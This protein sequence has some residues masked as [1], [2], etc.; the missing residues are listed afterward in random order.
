MLNLYPDKWDCLPK[1]Q[2]KVLTGLSLE[3]QT[4]E[5]IVMQVFISFL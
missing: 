4:F 5:D 2:P 3:K 1:Q